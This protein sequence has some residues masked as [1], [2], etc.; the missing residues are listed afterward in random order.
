[1]VLIVAQLPQSAPKYEIGMGFQAR[2][3]AIAEPSG[4]LP[5]NQ[6]FATNAGR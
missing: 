4:N 3:F 2:L 1:L 6:C 5:A